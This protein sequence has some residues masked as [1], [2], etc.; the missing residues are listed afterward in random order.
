MNVTIFCSANDVGEP[1]TSA[2]RSL[3]TLIARRGGTLVWGGSNKGTMREIADAAQE[4]GGKIVGVSVEPI[5]ASAREHADEMVIAKTWPE[6]RATLL[7]RGDAIV[8]L[9]G[10]IGTLDE[11]TEVLEYKKQNL[12]QK[13]IVFLNT[14]GFFDGMKLQFERMDSEGFLPKKLADLL[15]FAA[16]PEEALDYIVNYRSGTSEATYKE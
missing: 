14:N 11:I 2:A 13:P 3:A 15:F 9:P 6:R 4:A 1:Y 10:G 12:H 8:A 5:K 7:A 16:T